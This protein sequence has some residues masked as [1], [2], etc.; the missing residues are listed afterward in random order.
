[1]NGATPGVFAGEAP[2][3]RSDSRV[4]EEYQTYRDA[5]TGEREMAGCPADDLFLSGRISNAGVFQGRCRKM[6]L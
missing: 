2:S 3:Q 6:S 1:M 5:E 4:F